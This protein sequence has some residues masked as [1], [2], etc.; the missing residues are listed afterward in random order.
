M[1]PLFVG[2]INKE[3]PKSISFGGLVWLDTHTSPMER[4][5]RISTLL[6]P[7][8]GNRR[9]FP[10]SGLSRDATRGSRTW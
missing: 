1:V 9:V 7:R 3:D 2:P 10:P 5:S 4:F 6:L 8:S